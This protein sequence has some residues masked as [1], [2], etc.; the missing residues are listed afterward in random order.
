MQPDYR[1]LMYWAKL[2]APCWANRPLLCF[3]K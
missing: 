1:R 2:K 3:E